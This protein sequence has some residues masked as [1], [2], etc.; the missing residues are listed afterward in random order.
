MISPAVEDAYVWKELKRNPVGKSDVLYF[1]L[2]LKTPNGTY[3]SPVIKPYGTLPRRDFLIA[4]EIM[5]QSILHSK[6]M[7]GVECLV[8]ITSTFGPKCTKCLD[9]ITGMIRDSHCSTCYGTGRAPAYHGPY[10]SWVEFSPDVE[11]ITETSQTGTTEKKSFQARMIG[12]PGLKQGD[13]V[14]V[15]S[16]DKRYYISKVSK[17]TEIRR[18][19]ILQ[20]LILE[21]APL[22]DKIYD[23]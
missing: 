20:D 8:Y 19:P 18:V 23:L 15:P 21:E 4:R 17:T 5:R 7:G 11:H 13:I 22:T 2:S 14:I 9:P 1:R 3:V 6:G 16:S 12:N 10:T